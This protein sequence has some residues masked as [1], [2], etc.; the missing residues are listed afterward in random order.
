MAGWPSAGIARKS[1]RRTKVRLTQTSWRGSGGRRGRGGG[2]A[3]G[4]QTAARQDV[5]RDVDRDAQSPLLLIDPGRPREPLVLVRPQPEHVASG[6]DCRRGSGGT[7]RARTSRQRR[8][9]VDRPRSPVAQTGEDAH[10]RSRMRGSHVGRAPSDHARDSGRGRIARVRRVPLSRPRL[11]SD[12]DGDMLRCGRTRNQRLARPAW[13]D[14]KQ[15]LC[16][17]GRHRDRRPGAR[18]LPAVSGAA[19]PAPRPPLPRQ[20]VCG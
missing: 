16:A 5:D 7:R 19:A 12:P 13:I 2:T 6:S 15:G 18:G 1:P 3:H 10:M 8:A 14:Q 11:Q 9:A 17:S 20:E 4:G